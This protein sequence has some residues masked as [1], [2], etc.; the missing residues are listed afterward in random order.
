MGLFRLKF[1]K[2]LRLIEDLILPPAVLGDTPTLAT[3]RFG[4]AG[5]SIL[6]WLVRG[7]LLNSGRRGA[8]PAA[9]GVTFSSSSS[10][11]LSKSSLENGSCGLRKDEKMS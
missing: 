6:T 2:G 11:L 4:E 10:L 7:H 5:F 1:F 3:L 8:S 9:D